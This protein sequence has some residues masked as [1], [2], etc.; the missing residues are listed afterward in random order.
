MYEIKNQADYDAAMIALKRHVADAQKA[1]RLGHVENMVDA[2]NDANAE[3]ARM[4]AW[5]RGEA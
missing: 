3:S 5:L 1:K 4:A 2:I